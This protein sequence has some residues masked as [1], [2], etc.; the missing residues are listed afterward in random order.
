MSGQTAR[1]LVYF[2]KIHVVELLYE[3]TKQSELI[4]ESI[5]Y[6]IQIDLIPQALGLI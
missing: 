2:N 3:E 1:T 6:C 4:S 5:L